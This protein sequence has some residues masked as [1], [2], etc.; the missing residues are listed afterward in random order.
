M[1]TCVVLGAG[2]GVGNAVA[3]AFANRGYNLA[4][5]ARKVA[6]LELFKEE[7]TKNCKVSSHSIDVGDLEALKSEL[8]N[9]SATIGP[10]EVLVFNAYAN[11][12]ARPTNLEIANFV[13][14][15]NVNV[16]AALVAAQAVVEDMRKQGKGTLL[17]TGGGR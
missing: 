2:P 16:A 8:K 13:G 1:A 5:C 6:K 12:V 4:L 3:K 7:M 9:I 11:P 17:F 10:V 15:L 14:S